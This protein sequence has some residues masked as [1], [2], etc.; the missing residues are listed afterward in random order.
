MYDQ[1]TLLTLGDFDSGLLKSVDMVLV[2]D[3][4]LCYN[5]IRINFRQPLQID[6]K[7]TSNCS[8][9][10]V[11]SIIYQ[12]HENYYKHYAFHNFYAQAGLSILLELC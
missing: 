7:N 3:L 12:K 1:L 9:H 5:I 10:F 4:R 11:E 2:F 8:A 6:L